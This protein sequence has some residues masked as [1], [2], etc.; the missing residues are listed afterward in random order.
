MFNIIFSSSTSITIELVNN[1]VYNTK[2]YDIYLNDVLYASGITKNVY[3]IFNLK[4]DTDYK[5]S[6]NDYSLEV[7]TDYEYVCLNVLDFGAKGDG[8]NNDT[9]FI[10]ACINACPKDSRVYIPAGKYYTGPLFLRDN[11]TI[12]LHKDAHLIGDTD[13]THYPILPGMTYTTDEKG[14]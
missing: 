7:K 3:S 6:I 9:N 8:V 10:Q 5:I 11:I 1:D 12:E 13:R 14:E 2:K 4:P